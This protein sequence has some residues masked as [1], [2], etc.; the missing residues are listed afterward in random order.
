MPNPSHRFGLF[1]KLGIL[2]H[3]NYRALQMFRQAPEAVIPYLQQQFYVL[4]KAELTAEKE[5]LQ[6]KLGEYAF[7]AKMKQL[8][9]QS[10]QLFRAE[11]AER[12]PWQSGRPLFEKQDFR[13]DS[14]GW[15]QSTRLF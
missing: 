12:Y 14:A 6:K 11:L 1:Q 3:F 15:L 10:L 5:A 4:R 7:D 13:Q 8:E 9:Q 2:F